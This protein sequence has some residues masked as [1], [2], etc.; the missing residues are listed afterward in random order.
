[1]L[2]A[3]IISK[4][5]GLLG[6][7]EYHYCP[8]GFTDNFLYAISEPTIKQLL[9]DLLFSLILYLYYYL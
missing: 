2:V 8:S 6:L 1:M 9:L 7:V 5:K 3:F 4:K